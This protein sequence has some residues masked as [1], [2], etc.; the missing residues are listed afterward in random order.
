[1]CHALGGPG[2]RMAVEA[3]A[4]SIEHGCYLDDDP[5]LMKMMADKGI[6]FVPTFSVYIFH[7]DRGT[8]HG[9]ERAR[10]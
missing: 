4:N 3:G 2:L 6:F 8:P 10:P 5:E 1:M 7:G 9:Q